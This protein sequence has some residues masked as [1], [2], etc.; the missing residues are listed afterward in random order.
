MVWPESIS[1]IY[2]KLRVLSVARF[3]AAVAFSSITGSH[4]ESVAVDAEPRRVSIITG[5]CSSWGT[6]T[7]VQDV[8]SDNRTPLS[9]IALAACEGVGTR[10]YHRVVASR[11]FWIPMIPSDECVINAASSRLIAGVIPSLHLRPSSFLRAS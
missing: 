8:E 2:K 9:R 3:L 7:P 1:C 6:R 4:R 10:M 11:G 5:I